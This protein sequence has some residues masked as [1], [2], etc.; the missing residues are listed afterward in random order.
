M[1]S[2]NLSKAHLSVRRPR[3][4][5]QGP[6]EAHGRNR[7]RGLWI[8]SGAVSICFCNYDVRFF[9]IRY[10]LGRRCLLTDESQ[11]FP[12]F[13]P[14]ATLLIGISKFMS[15]CSYICRRPLDA[16]VISLSLSIST[17]RAY[18]WPAT[19]SFSDHDF[20][21]TSLGI[22]AIKN[23]SYKQSWHWDSPKAM[24]GKSRPDL[25]ITLAMQSGSTAFLLKTV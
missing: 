25:S 11:P 2:R 13:L 24:D 6:G 12:V 14:T 17:W 7:Q 18:P 4:A 20:Q 23:V 1:D 21:T 15:I 22:P 9:L 8:L 19:I 16:S 5:L 10:G 3:E